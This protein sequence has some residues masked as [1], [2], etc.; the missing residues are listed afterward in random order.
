MQSLFGTICVINMAL[1][2]LLLFLQ[3]IS[4]LDISRFLGIVTLLPRLQNLTLSIPGWR[5]TNIMSSFSFM[6]WHFYLLSLNLGIT[7]PPLFSLPRPCS[8]S[9]LG[10]LWAQLSSLSS[11]EDQPVF[12]LL[13]TQVFLEVIILPFGRRIPRISS[14]SALRDSSSSSH[15]RIPP[16]S[17]RKS[18]VEESIVVKHTKQMALP[19][20]LMMTSTKPLVPLFL[21]VW[22]LLFFLLILFFPSLSQ[23]LEHPSSLT[24][25]LSNTLLKLVQFMV[26]W[27]MHKIEH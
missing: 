16:S 27:C 8:S 19:N 24:G 13:V 18:M 6:Q 10:I 4:A 14:S 11:S 17:K 5:K 26:H 21:Q 9:W 1:L 23:K 7:W 3:T 25:S 2:G 22:L 15:K 20:L 12:I